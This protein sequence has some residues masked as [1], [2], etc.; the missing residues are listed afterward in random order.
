MKIYIK[1]SDIVRRSLW[2]KYVDYVMIGSTEEELKKILIEDKEFEINEEDAL[3]IDLLK[4]IE[5]PNLNY[6]LNKILIDFLNQRSIK[7][8]LDS[9]YYVNKKGILKAINIFEKNFP[10][11]FKTTDKE[12]LEGINHVKKYSKDL[13]KKI[14]KIDITIIKINEV[15]MEC[16]PINTV[17]KMINMFV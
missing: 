8:N 1:P 3:V 6:K 7:N 12:Y 9:K 17:K 2:R 4:V 5:T 10:D 15:S 13:V 14:D 16:V 11:Y